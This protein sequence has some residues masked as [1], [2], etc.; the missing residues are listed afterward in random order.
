M[1]ILHAT[2]SS[3]EKHAPGL[4]HLSSIAAI[5]QLKST[6]YARLVRGHVLEGDVEQVVEAASVLLGASRRGVQFI[7]IAAL[8]STIP[9]G[10]P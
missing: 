3:V 1:H 5:K 4:A 10:I 6:R 8:N 7:M 9:S 2:N